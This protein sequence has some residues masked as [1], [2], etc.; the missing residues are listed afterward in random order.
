MSAKSE[1]SDVPKT[2]QTKAASA[3]GWFLGHDLLV[4]VVAALL[5]IGGWLAYTSSSE[6]SSSTFK[7]LGLT[8][9]Y[10]AGWLPDAPFSEE[11][12]V[13]VSYASIEDA[14]VRVNV[15]ISQ[16]PPVEGPI[17]TVLALRRARKHGEM[18][19]ALK[20]EIKT[21]GGLE[22]TRTEYVYAFKPTE[23]AE[24][25]LANAVEYGIVNND[26]LY[27]VSVHGPKDR[28]AALEREILGTLSV[29]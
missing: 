25:Q 10:P 8:F 2:S 27:A 1:K 14:R 19:K 29:Q 7:R 5:L 3:D 24:P 22:W 15:R 17:D 12:P 4:H 23:D 21:M 18:Y 6:A 9:S 16:K 28:V 11:L 20:T 13:D 26:K